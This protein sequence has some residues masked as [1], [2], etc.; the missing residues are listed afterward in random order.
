M[1]R[2]QRAVRS[3]GWAA[4]SKK[5]LSYTCLVCHGHYTSPDLPAISSS[6]TRRSMTMLG[7]R[8]WLCP[9]IPYD[10]VRS[11]FCHLYNGQELLY[12]IKSITELGIIVKVTTG[13][14]LLCYHLVHHWHRVTRD[15]G[16]W[17]GIPSLHH[18]LWLERVI[19]VLALSPFPC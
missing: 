11:I 9:F 1:K 2:S 8:T 19:P 18:E 17:T 6:F 3:S 4:R 13:M 7:L 14:H 16:N 10:L 5:M 12:N 15:L